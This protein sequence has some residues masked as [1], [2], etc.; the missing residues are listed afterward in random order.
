[1]GR[2]CLPA[3]GIRGLSSK[4]LRWGK[5]DKD[6]AYCLQETCLVSWGPD[7]PRKCQGHPGGN[8]WFHC[9]GNWYL[10]SGRR[11]CHIQSRLPPPPLLPSQGPLSSSP[12]GHWTSKG[13]PDGPTSTRPRWPPVG[14][15]P[16]TRKPPLRLVLGSSAS[17]R[18]PHI[19]PRLALQGF[20]TAVVRGVCMVS[21]WL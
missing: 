5:G 8:T 14:F 21:F 19:E 13:D 11:C 2:I 12:S 15:S 4:E 9:P 10:V 1:M 16:C 20:Y 7:Q 17:T 18:V 6:P 3:P